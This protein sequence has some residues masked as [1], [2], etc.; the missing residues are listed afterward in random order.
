[1]EVT[2][3]ASIVFEYWTPGLSLGL[4][5]S[6]IALLVVIALGVSGRRRADTAIDAA[7]PLA[8]SF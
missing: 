1:V 5:I 7:R 8:S 4:T 6:G 3:D 2:G